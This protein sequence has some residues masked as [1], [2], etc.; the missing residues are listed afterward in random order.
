MT[1]T[2]AAEYSGFFLLLVFTLILWL[3]E[4]MVEELHLMQLGQPAL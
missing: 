1:L 2:K 4:G 3:F